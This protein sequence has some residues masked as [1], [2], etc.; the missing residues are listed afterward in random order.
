MSRYFWIIIYYYFIYLLTR[1][2]DLQIRPDSGK[3]SLL[4]FLT[5]AYMSYTLCVLYVCV[6]WA[7]RVAGST[8]S[9]LRAHNTPIMHP[10]PLTSLISSCHFSCPWGTWTVDVYLRQKIQENAESAC[11]KEI[12]IVTIKQKCFL[13]FRVC[14]LFQLCRHN[15]YKK[16]K[17]LTL[18]LK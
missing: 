11:L 3:V 7:G 4:M 18:H 16:C 10:W 17:L 6:H 14:F 12:G 2:N 9:T 13:K 8:L 5:F 1:W 15:N